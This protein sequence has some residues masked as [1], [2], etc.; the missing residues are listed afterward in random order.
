MLLL[1][2]AATAEAQTAPG[3][4]ELGTIVGR[5]LDANGLAPLDAANVLLEPLSGTASARS[6]ATSTG[7]SGSYLFAGLLPG[8][9]RLTMRRVGYASQAVEV[10]LEP[11]SEAHVSLGL[12]VAPVTLRPLQVEAARR[13]LYGAPG[14]H[15]AEQRDA[16]AAAARVRQTMY[17]AADVREL[18]HGE[19]VEAVTLGETDLFRALQRIPGV[20]T[21]DDYTAVLWTRGAQWDQTRVFF[22]GLPLFNPTHA[23]WVFSAINPDGVGAVTFFPG[24]RSA[25]WGEGAAA[26][27]DVESREGGRRGALSA[28]AEASVVTGRLAADGEL[29]DGGVTWMVAGRRTYLDWFSRAVQVFDSAGPGAIPYNFSDAIGRV[30][31]RIGS[32]VGGFASGLVERDYLRGDVPGVLV[33]NRA[34]WGNRA[35]QISVYAPLGPVQATVSGGETH[36]ATAVV[37]QEQPRRPLSSLTARR[38]AT[39]LD[40]LNNVVDRRSVSLRVQPLGARP[41]KWAMGVQWVRQNV[42]YSGPYSPIAQLVPEVGGDSLAGLFTYTSGLAYTALWGERRWVPHAR[43]ELETGVRAEYGASVAAAGRLRLAPRLSGRYWVD[44]ATAVS[45]SWARTYQYMQDIGPAA[46]PV[47]PQ[48]H[49][50]HFWVSA[51]S[52][53]RPAIRADVAQ[54][55]IE[56]RPARDWWLVANLYGRR[57]T[58]LRI[59]NPE[60]GQV[61]ESRSPEAA[62]DNIAYG[63]EASA[64]RLGGRWTGAASYAYGVSTLDARSA[65]PE[66]PGEWH[67]P[68]PADIRHSVDLTSSVRL[69]RS[70]QAGGAFT[71]ASGVP[72]TQFVI[73]DAA[74]LR[75]PNARRTSP[76]ASLDLQAEYTRTVGAWQL[77]GFVQLR[78]ALNRDNR[79]TYLGSREVC[80]LPL[81]NAGAAPCAT[82][83]VED[84]F[85]TGVPRVPL[86]GVRVVF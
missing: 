42:T 58:G 4:P 21:R 12:V 86:V 23:G 53:V 2:A 83:R 80:P 26:V 24:Y 7:A 60:P 16:R 55:G 63:L 47:G 65:D 19:V 20:T 70:W 46:G 52:V 85:Q 30:D 3:P 82:R 56:H 18:T 11:G 22:D 37:R 57:G 1:T 29:L 72:F 59:A 74:E 32:G 73:G 67:F 49:L 66:R 44:T 43:W 69:T 50:T 34:R 48:L 27:L 41:R 78:N 6:R 79:I 15:S 25:E 64:R 13:Q 36:F 14:T 71:Y 40:T 33:G 77:S 17:T 61:L 10:D 35:G 5:V 62:A 76:Y 75:E 28:S 68:S 45:A 51:Q 8:R 54:L 31:F 39:T 9:Y 38:A 84:R 81:A